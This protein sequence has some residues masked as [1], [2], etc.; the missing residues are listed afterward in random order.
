MLI[1]NQA[2]IPETG[3]L[4]QIAMAFLGLFFYYKQANDF[5]S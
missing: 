1:P 3:I 5:W 4:I 2:P